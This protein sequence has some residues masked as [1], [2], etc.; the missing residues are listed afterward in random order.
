MQYSP[1]V[2]I[3]QV[4][5]IFNDYRAAIGRYTAARL[6]PLQHKFEAFYKSMGRIR[7]EKQN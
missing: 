2:N 7:V 5:D 6:T 3:R 4:G 1:S